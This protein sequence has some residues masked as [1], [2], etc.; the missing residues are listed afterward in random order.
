MAV[1]RGRY[2]EAARLVGRIGALGPIRPGV[3]WNVV[4]AD[5]LAV[6]DAVIGGGDTVTASAAVR[7]LEQQ[8]ATRATTGVERF[9]EV[10]DLCAIGLWRAKRGEQQATLPTIARRLRETIAAHDSARFFGSSG[11]LC[12]LM[13]D[14]EHAVLL[15][16]PDARAVVGRL[17]SLAR[18][19]PAEF[20]VGFVNVVL[21]R[22]WSRIGDNNTAL[23][24]SRRRLYDWT[25]GARYFSAHVR[26][27]AELS[28]RTGNTA[29]AGNARRVL[30][31]LREQ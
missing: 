17:D 10:G 9:R 20:G 12:A 13:L 31:A 11:E 19:A 22:L 14:A 29:E 30:E 3:V 26:A 7:R 27:E 18:E 21:A 2:D 4:D 15:P 1:N 16:R 25:T 5:A 8:T 6:T 28:Q 24:A 23:L